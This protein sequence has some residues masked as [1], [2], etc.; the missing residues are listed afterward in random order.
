[1][2]ALIVISLIVGIILGQF[3]GGALRAAL[4]V[5]AVVLF[6][7][8]ASSHFDVDVKSWLGDGI[9]AGSDAV[10]EFQQKPVKHTRRTDRGW[11]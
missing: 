6:L 1:M 8:F 7:G 3:L 9:K 4:I 10:E 11:L 2:I 5:G